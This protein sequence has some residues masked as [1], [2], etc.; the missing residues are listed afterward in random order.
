MIDVTDIVENFRRALSAVVPCA[1]RAGVPWRR[2]DAYDEWDAVASALY[3]SLVVEPIRWQ[4]SEANW[5]SFSLPDYDLLRPHYGE[6][7]WIV[8]GGSKPKEG[9]FLFH[10]FATRKQPFDTVEIRRIS[11]SGSPLQPGDELI[12]RPAAGSTYWLVRR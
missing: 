8:V 12:E 9:R 1:E 2:P 3:R 10:A 4:L 7:S 11:D 6:F 5:E